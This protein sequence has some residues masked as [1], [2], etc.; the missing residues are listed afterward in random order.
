MFEGALRIEEIPEEVP[1]EPPYLG[2]PEFPQYDQNYFI[3]KIQKK[4][5]LYEVHIFYTF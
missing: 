1:I 3:T 5:L 2:W 4:C